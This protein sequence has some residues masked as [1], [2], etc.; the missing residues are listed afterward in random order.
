MLQELNES[1]FYM[2]PCP[3]CG[4]PAGQVQDAVNFLK[5]HHS[6]YT[7]FWLDIEGPQYWSTNH[8]TNQQFFGSLVSE[9]LK[10]NQTLGV[11]TSESQWNP[12]FGSAYNAGAK[13]PLWYAH[14]DNN[15]SFSDFTPFNG[16]TSPSMKQY[17]GDDDE[18][19]TNIDKDWTP[20][21]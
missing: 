16:W 14:Y 21:L 2:F 3:T 10:L 11:Y 15:P 18:C 17:A 5:S 1:M 4:N 19:N 7:M 6:S 13:Y 9:A 8:N 12:I 20:Y